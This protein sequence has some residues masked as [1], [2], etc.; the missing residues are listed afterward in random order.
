MGPG[1][2]VR[3]FHFICPHIAARRNL[4]LSASVEGG[5]QMTRAKMRLSS[6][7]GRL[8]SQWC[9][10]TDSTVKP[11]K[12]GLIAAPA[13]SVRAHSVFHLKMHAH[14]PIQPTENPHRTIGSAMTHRARDDRTSDGPALLDRCLEIL[15]G[16]LGAVVHRPRRRGVHRLDGGRDRRGRR[17]PRRRN[18]TCTDRFGRCYSTCAIAVD[19]TPRFDVGT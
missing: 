17:R 8:I 4:S 12:A 19:L 5:W 2:G 11:R 9:I 13:R 16:D 7:P 1:P 10:R 3:A 15:L 14:D 6:W 18:S